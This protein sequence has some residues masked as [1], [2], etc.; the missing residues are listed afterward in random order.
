MSSELSAKHVNTLNMRWLRGRAE[1]A[2]TIDSLCP[3]VES[4]VMSWY[5]DL[6]ANSAEAEDEIKKRTGKG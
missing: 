1:S 6:D 4:K 5:E 2:P 3:D